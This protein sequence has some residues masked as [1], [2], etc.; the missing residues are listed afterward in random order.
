MEI[1]FQ[2]LIGHW[3][4]ELNASTLIPDRSCKRIIPFKMTDLSCHLQLAV[5]EFITSHRRCRLTVESESDSE[6]EII[7]DCQSSHF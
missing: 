5:V 4:S 2:C 1:K 7:G 3:D 6:I